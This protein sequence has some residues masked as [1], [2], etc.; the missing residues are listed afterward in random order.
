MSKIII[1]SLQ[2]LIGRTASK[3]VA[4][5]VF[6]HKVH[7]GDETAMQLAKD[8]NW[9]GLSVYGS[10]DVY[11]TVGDLNGPNVKIGAFKRTLKNGHDQTKMAA[12]I[13][14]SMLG[15]TIE[16]QGELLEGVCYSLQAN[17]HLFRM[18]VRC[19]G[20]SRLGLQI[21]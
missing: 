12:S 8:L 1:L 5:E 10:P 17:I 21:M 7:G 14:S 18:V 11:G 16:V 6:I 13:I 3:Q 15:P 4:E 20:I 2:S 9:C 19:K